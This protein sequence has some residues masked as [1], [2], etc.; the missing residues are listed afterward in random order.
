MIVLRFPVSGLFDWG[1][2]EPQNPRIRTVLHIF[3]THPYF[4]CVNQ[5]VQFMLSSCS[6]NWVLGLFKPVHD[7]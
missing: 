5:I 4:L 1:C 6:T 2:T 3:D 7:L